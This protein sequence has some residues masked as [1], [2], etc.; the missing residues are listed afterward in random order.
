ME[1]N[2]QDSLEVEVGAQGSPE[3]PQFSP[4]PPSPVFEVPE[5]DAST[6]MG[7]HSLDDLVDFEEW[8]RRS[9]ELRGTAD[10]LMVEPGISDNLRL[11][12]KIHGGCTMAI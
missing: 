12:P 7:L 5:G 2:Y 4:G 3:S 1:S 9:R 8:A 10:Y 6:F 11:F